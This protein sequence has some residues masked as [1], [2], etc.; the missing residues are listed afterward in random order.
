MTDFPALQQ[1]I[2]IIGSPRSGTSVLSRLFRRHP[3]LHLINEPRLIW[4]RGNDM[5]SDML[6]P[7]HVTPAIKQSIREAFSKEMVQANKSRLLEKTP[8]NALRVGFVDQ[9][10][11]DA[12]YIHMIRDGLSSIMSIREYWQTSATGMRPA[13]RNV[14]WRRMREIKP[15]QV[16]YYAGELLRRV[17]GKWMPG[18]KK[19]VWGP[20]LPGINQMVNDL[21]LLEVCAMQWRF[22]IESAT[23]DGRKLPHDRYTEC[24]LN[25][26]DQTE[27]SRL[28]DFCKLPE[29]PEVIAGFQEEFDVNKPSKRAK[30]FDAKEV[31]LVNEII[32]PTVAWLATLEPVRRHL[33]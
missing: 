24:Y 18:K 17:M 29:S 32:A 9:I 2:V 19:S 14:L 5:R 27:L 33:E 23:R 31:D 6:R 26:L 28:L 16:P 12:I 1:P 20:R 4:K 30:T 13:I 10:L 22:C 3:D 25:E 21:D 8:S 11:D 15:S 7:N